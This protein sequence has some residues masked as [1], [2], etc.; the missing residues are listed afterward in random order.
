MML[1]LDVSN[2]G[3]VRDTH[4]VMR[5]R[6]FR[7][8]PSLTEGTANSF[9]LLGRRFLL[10]DVVVQ[11][12]HEKGVGVRQHPF[13]NG[14]LEPC[15]IDTLKH[16]NGMSG[17]LANELLKGTKAQKKSSSVPEIPCWNCIGSDHCG[18]S[19]KGQAT[20]RTSV[21]VEKRLFE[22]RGVSACLGRINSTQHKC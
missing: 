16:R 15:L 12:E 9:N 7:H 6:G 20:R 18:F 13:V 2:F 17:D 21:I 1:V 5:A 14:K 3:I 10:R 4:I 8:V 11:P 22:F 19:Y